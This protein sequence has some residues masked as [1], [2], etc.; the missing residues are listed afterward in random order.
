MINE[1]TEEELKAIDK[2]VRDFVVKL[3][4][5]DKEQKQKRFELAKKE[6]VQAK[7]DFIESLDKNQL[8]LYKSFCKKKDAF[9]SWLSQIE[10]QKF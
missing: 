5:M 8:R 6:M 9:Y 10:E 7:T 2:E 1:Y 3:T 4:S